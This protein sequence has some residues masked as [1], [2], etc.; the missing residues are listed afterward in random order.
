VEDGVIDMDVELIGLNI[1]G[2]QK[3]L[4]KTRHNRKA[5]RVG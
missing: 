5:I 3:S 2:V 4:K 1:S